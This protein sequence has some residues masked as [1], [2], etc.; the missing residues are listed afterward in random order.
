MSRR[1]SFKIDSETSQFL[2]AL[3]AGKPANLYVLLWTLPEKRSRW[4]Q[5]VDPTIEF[6]AS[7]PDRDLY[8]GVAL[9][10]QVRSPATPRSAAISRNSLSSSGGTEI[11]IVVDCSITGLNSG[12]VTVP[13]T[14]RRRSPI[15]FAANS[16][17]HDDNRC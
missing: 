7:M 1:R 15:S 11:T 6:A 10:G 14:I 2:E 17:P 5:D 9:A 4:F 8:V 3:F 16:V 12:F 13:I